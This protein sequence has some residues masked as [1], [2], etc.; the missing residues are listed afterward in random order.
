[1][2]VDPVASMRC[3]AIALEIGGREYEIPALPAADWWP[4]LLSGGPGRVIDLI[5]SRMGGPDDLDAQLLAGE[6]D[7][8]ELGSAL[9][10]AIEEATGRSVHVAT[11]LAVIADDRWDIIGPA[12]AQAG[13]RWDQQPIGAA[14]DLI[15][16]I[17]TAGM[18]EENRGKFFQLLE[19][20]SLTQPGR[21]R[22]PSQEVVKEFEAMA[23]P[24]P[25]P[26]PLPGR[27]SA[28]PSDGARPK[29]RRQ[30][31]QRHQV[32]RSAEPS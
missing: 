16:G 17:V 3:W 15:Y 19:N 28:V 32:G 12:I 11:V 24:R 22:E 25:A 14:L 10:E 23:G 7:G 5:P 21:K 9:T 31:R 13:F 20:E 18:N 26:R 4:I 6:V 27:S 1:M 30:P 29:T 2:R 8:K